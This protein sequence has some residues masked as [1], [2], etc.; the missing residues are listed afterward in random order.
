M[1]SGRRMTNTMSFRGR[2]FQV[3]EG[4]THPAY[5][6]NCFSETEDEGAFRAAH[7]N[8][9]PGDV[10]VDVGASYGAYS[11][12]AAVMGGRV[13]AFEPEPT[14]FVDLRRNI[15]L[16]NW[17]TKVVPLPWALWDS[18]GIVNMKD[19]APHWPAQTITSP[20]RTVALDTYEPQKLDWLKIDVEGAEVHVLRGAAETLKRCKPT[21]IVEVHTFLNPELMPQCRA[22]LE[23]AGYERFEE[24]DRE[25]CVMLIG[26]PS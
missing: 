25:P 17:E 14:V 24:Y 12:T 7:W 1:R 13:L 6:L 26:R 23:A 22:L 5:S 11:L 3:V 8:I 18:E 10:V 20:Y 19:W 21:V 9:Q 4:S 15:E 2:S 16:N